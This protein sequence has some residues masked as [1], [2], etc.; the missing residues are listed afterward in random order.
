MEVLIEYALIPVLKI[1]VIVFGVGMGLGSFLTFAERKQSAFIQ[2]RWGPNRANIGPIRLFGL[3]HILADTVKLLLKED[4]VPENAHRKLH[5][6]A[7]ALGLLPCM[8]IFGI[9]PFMDFYCH[10]TNIVIDGMDYCFPPGGPGAGV[11][12]LQEI[13][14]PLYNAELGHYFQ[15]ADLNAG[16][17]YMFAVTGVGV[18]GSAIAGWASNSKFSL[19]GGLRAA[20]QMISYEIA[21]GLSLAGLLMIY[22][23]VDVNDMVRE[24][25]E[26]LFGFLPKW[27]LFL[28]PLAFVLFLTA[29][30]AESKRGPFDMPEAES[31]LVAGYFT[32]YSS[33]KFAIFSLGEFVMVVFIAAITATLFLGG[34]QVP[35]LYADGFHF[36]FEAWTG[37]AT[38][39]A[40][41]VEAYASANAP[42]LALPYWSVWPLRIGFFLFKI[43][44]MCFLQLQIRWTLPRFRYDQVMHL[45]W[46]ILLPVS[47]ANLVVT[48]V[49]LLWLN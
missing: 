32:E 20:A 12:Y 15:I 4:I 37:G 40:G 21:M 13:S 39:T 36:T 48:A 45:G 24:Q 9:V 47:L 8:V 5:F 31:E 49:V 10:G 1:S 6:I 34:W 29:S 11:V 19:M 14:N 7:P 17:L 16:I 25:G 38:T 41:A 33:M 23:T 43:V 30:I 3:V 27:G 35:W 22:A 46:K 28:Q 42:D 26:L 18:Y 44:L 2:R